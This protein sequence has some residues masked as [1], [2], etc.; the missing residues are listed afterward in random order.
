[1]SEPF[2]VTPHTVEF[3]VAVEDGRRVGSMVTWALPNH[4]DHL[5]VDDPDKQPLYEV[6][7]C[8]FEQNNITVV[9][10]PLQSDMPT[11]QSA[12]SPFSRQAPGAGGFR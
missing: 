3:D 11:A 10:R 7:R 2:Q 4:G 5:R 1:M 9:V 12:D 6:V 8:D